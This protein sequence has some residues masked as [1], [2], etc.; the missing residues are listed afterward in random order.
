MIQTA[1]HSRRILFWSVIEMKKLIAAL[2][3]AALLVSMAGVALA[4][5]VTVHITGN[6][7][8]RSGPSLNRRILGTVSE[9]TTLKG[10][11]TVRR[12]DRDVAWYEVTY[13]GEKGWVS[14]K[15][16]YTT[17]KKSST[18]QYVIGDTGKSNVHTGPGLSYKVIG[19][20]RVDDSAR[21]LDKTSVDNR[22]VVWYKISWKGEDA[23]V[24][25]KYTRLGRKSSPSPEGTT[26]VAEDGNTN[27][28]TGPGLKYKSFDIMYE[29]DEADY[30][31]KS[32]TDSRGV[33]WYKISWYGDV[34]WVSSR[35]TYLY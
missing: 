22:G 4:D 18:K 14:S 13:R 12:D 33:V 7:N 10:S 11:G 23:W 30:L 26:V 17:G 1:V 6:C 3:L 29:G 32:S 27:V 20:L 34:G 35:Y 8:V 19:V 5:S 21:F 15:Y 2:V 31:G 24:S 9:G 28:R 25:S 16:A